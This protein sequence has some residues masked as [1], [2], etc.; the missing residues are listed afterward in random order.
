MTLPSRRVLNFAGFLACAGMM[1]FALYAQHF[2]MLDPCPLCVLQRVVVIGLGALFLLAALH[3]PAGWGRTV[4][5]ALLLLVAV[6]GVAVA[7][8]HVHLQNLPPEE[9][10]SCGPGIGY[11]LDN[12]PLTDAL[13]MVFEG[14]GEC[15]EVVWSFLGLS[16]PAWVLVCL[17]MVGA[18]GTWNNLRE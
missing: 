14:S 11:M 7:G 1:G 10:P 5:V 8:W 17:A 2:L 18:G 13:R 15:A 3:N 9:V 16:M 6:S 12:F 4:Y